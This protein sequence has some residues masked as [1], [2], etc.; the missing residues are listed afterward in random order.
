MPVLLTVE[1]EVGL[2][3]APAPDHGPDQGRKMYGRNG[4]RFAFG[5]RTRKTTMEYWFIKMGK[6]RYSFDGMLFGF[7]KKLFR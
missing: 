3:G 1:A 4:V 7:R 6:L 5:R 2:K